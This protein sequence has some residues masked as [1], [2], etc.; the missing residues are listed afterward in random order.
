MPYSLEYM[1][2][3]FAQI[4]KNIVLYLPRTSDLNQIARF[5]EGEDK[6]QVVHYCTQEKS[7]ALCVY[8]GEWKNT[9]DGEEREIQH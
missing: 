4:T 1:Y 5:V 8:F 7:K 6:A 2:T 3:R 9:A